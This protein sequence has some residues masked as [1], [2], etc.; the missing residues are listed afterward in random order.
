MTPKDA[1]VVLKHIGIVAC[2]APGAALC[3]RTICAESAT[4]FGGYAHPQISL[5]SHSFDDY[6]RHLEADDWDAIV[7]LMVDSADRLTKAGAEFLIC[8]DNT[9]HQALPAVRERT[10]LPWL[11]IA[12]VVSEDAVRRGLRHAGLLGT[13]WLVQ[14]DVYPEVLSAR[15]VACLRPDERDRREVDRVIMEELVHGVFES[16]ST[17]YLLDLIDNFKA[18]GCDSVI[19]GCTELPLVID[20]ENSTLPPL[21]STGLLATAAIETAAKAATE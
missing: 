2:S 7:E 9:I 14:S 3:Y 6:V 18:Q 8:P 16:D 21:N 17:K 1:I 12:E 10:R 19:L 5:H 13:R 15:G 20:S 4:K 11:H